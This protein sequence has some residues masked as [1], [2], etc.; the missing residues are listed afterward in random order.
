MSLAWSAPF[1]SDFD[2]DTSAQ[3][4]LDHLIEQQRAEHPE[5]TST[6]RS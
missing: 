5:S 2:P 4:M 3:Q 6:V 1:P